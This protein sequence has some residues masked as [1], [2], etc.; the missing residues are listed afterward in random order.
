M[1]TNYFSGGIGMRVGAEKAVIVSKLADI[2]QLFISRS[3]ISHHRVL[4]ASF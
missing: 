4:P 3:V 1:L 2:S